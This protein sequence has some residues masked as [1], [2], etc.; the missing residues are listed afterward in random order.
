[1][2]IFAQFKPGDRIVYSP[3]LGTS[4]KTYYAWLKEAAAEG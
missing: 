1:M 2:N 3:E 4:P